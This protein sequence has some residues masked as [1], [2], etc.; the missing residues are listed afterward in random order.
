MVSSS[1]A[2]QG[3]DGSSSIVGLPCRSIADVLARL[4]FVLASTGGELSEEHEPGL[5][6]ETRQIERALRESI[7]FLQ[8]IAGFL[9]CLETCGYLSTNYLFVNRL[10]PIL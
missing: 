6:D 5:P 10:A 2:P 8:T 4:R 9:I 3:D 7:R 1:K